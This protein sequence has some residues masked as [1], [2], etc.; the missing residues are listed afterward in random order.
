MKQLQETRC[1]GPPQ[2]L[3]NFLSSPTNLVFKKKKKRICM[4]AEL[5]LIPTPP[6]TNHLFK[7]AL[8]FILLLIYGVMQFIFIFISF[9]TSFC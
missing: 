4:Y 3:R 1:M 5:L 2:F 8:N 9:H 7:I 6:G